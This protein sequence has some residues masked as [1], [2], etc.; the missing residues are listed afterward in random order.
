V[1]VEWSSEEL[2]IFEFYNWRCIL[3]C[4]RR[5]VTLHEI[6]PK[7]RRP[8]TWNDPNNRVPVCADCHFEIHRVGAKNFVSILKVKQKR[9]HAKSFQFR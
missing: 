9:C 6:I 3:C 2:Q 5:A 4:K 8:K 1:S 7:S